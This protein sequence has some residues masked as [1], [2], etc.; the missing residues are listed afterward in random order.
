V[1]G[2]VVQLLVTA[3]GH[4]MYARLLRGFQVLQV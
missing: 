2:L 1:S 3:A 4:Q